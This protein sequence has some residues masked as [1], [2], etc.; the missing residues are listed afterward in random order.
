MTRYWCMRFEV[1]NSHF[2]DI[3]HRIKN[4][5]NIPKSIASHHQFWSCYFNASQE[6]PM[7]EVA[8]GPG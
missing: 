6:C 4:F 8:I 3:V 5:K 2:K 1:K 7:Q